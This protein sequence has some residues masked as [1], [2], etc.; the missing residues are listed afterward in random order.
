MV[1]VYLYYLMGVLVG[2]LL[3]KEIDDYLNASFEDISSHEVITILRNRDFKLLL[4]MIGR[5]SWPVTL[6][7][8]MSLAFVERFYRVKYSDEDRLASWY[9]RPNSH[10]S[11]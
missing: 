8:L 3:D 9:I 2:K 1:G 11:H 7:F 6:L 10:R 4:K 5:I